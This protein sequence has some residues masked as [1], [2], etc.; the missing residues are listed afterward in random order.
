MGLF[1]PSYNLRRA[2]KLK[3]VPS[4][5]AALQQLPLGGGTPLKNTHYQGSYRFLSLDR[6]SLNIKIDLCGAAIAAPYTVICAL[7]PF[8][9][10][11]GGGKNPEIVLKSNVFWFFAIF[12]CTVIFPTPC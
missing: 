5:V 10:D 3:G 2:I 6:E 1:C 8:S 11:L 9:D 12:T 7:M 4:L